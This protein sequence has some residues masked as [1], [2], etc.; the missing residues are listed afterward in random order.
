MLK[1][2]NK[3][4]ELNIR[5]VCID[6]SK[7]KTNEYKT[8]S[9]H[10][11]YFFRG[12]SRDEDMF[13]NIIN[14]YNAHPGKYVVICGSNHLVEGEH[15]RSGKDTLGTRLKNTIPDKSKLIILS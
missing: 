9:A 13:N 12:E 10:G 6:S 2:L 5:V 7:I 15:F 1:I 11:Y 3:I 14:Q 4:R 8:K